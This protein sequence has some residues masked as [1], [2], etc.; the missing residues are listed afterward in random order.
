MAGEVQTVSR[1]DDDDL[2]ISNTLTNDSTEPKEEKVNKTTPTESASELSSASTEQIIQESQSRDEN[3]TDVLDNAQHQDQDE[4]NHHQP[5]E[6]I[7]IKEESSNSDNNSEPLP[8]TPTTAPPNVET[9]TSMDSLDLFPARP[10]SNAE[11]IDATKLSE[12]AVAYSADDDE[13]A[14]AEAVPVEVGNDQEATR[15]SFA[16]RAGAAAATAANGLS[17]A[18][19]NLSASSSPRASPT[20]SPAIKSEN[21]DDHQ[22]SSSSSPSN[23]MDR[24]SLVARAAAAAAAA[25]TATGIV[26]VLSTNLSGTPRTSPRTSPS[27]TP[28]RTSPISVARTWPDENVDDDS[29][30]DNGEAIPGSLPSPPRSSVGTGGL[31]AKPFPP[32]PTSNETA[33]T[34]RS[35]VDM[36]AYNPSPSTSP[37]AA[38]ENPNANTNTTM[39][40]EAPGSADKNDGEAQVLSVVPTMVEDNYEPKKVDIDVDEINN[41][42]EVPPPEDS[43]HHLKE[44]GEDNATSQH[45]LAALKAGLKTKKGKGILLACLLLLIGIGVGIGVSVAPEESS[46]CDA[47]RNGYPIPDENQYKQLDLN[48]IVDVSTTEPWETSLLK[49][50]KTEFQSVL[51]PIMAGC[52]DSFVDEDDA[53]VANGYVINARDMGD[54]SGSLP[55][56]CFSILLDFSIWVKGDDSTNSMEMIRYLTSSFGTTLA[57]QIESQSIVQV[58][59]LVLLEEV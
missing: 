40:I 21:E 20:A 28:A 11:L 38:P 3:E 45:S 7:I 14:V 46:N 18:L 16:A 32:L 39:D 54:C 10:D 53:R 27:R 9:V 5:E 12:T 52:K 25:A 36:D 47:V 56:P 57:D 13:P 35:P 33:A 59:E 42:R 23:I 49:E 58:A 17:T 48:W 43:A 29:F 2:E 41:G 50:I 31:G 24:P 6:A 34:T 1:M 4:R 44:S 22:A 19:S 8:M 37:M 15:P 30:F 55:R 26:P 51:L